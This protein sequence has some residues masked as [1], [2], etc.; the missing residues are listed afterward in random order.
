M[1]TT[2]LHLRGFVPAPPERVFDAWLDADTHSAFTGS[3]ATSE[4]GMYGRF[5]AYDG[6]IEGV[7]LELDRGHRIVQSWRTSEFLTKDPDSRLE[8]LLEPEN[9]GTQVTIIQTDVPTGLAARLEE[10][11]RDYY[12]DPLQRYFTK[13]SRP[14]KKPQSSAPTRRAPAQRRRKKA[15]VSK[16]RNV[17]KKPKKKAAKKKSATRAKVSKKKVARRAPTRKTAKKAPRKTTKKKAKSPAKK[18]IKK[19]GPRGVGNKARR[20]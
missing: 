5:S 20:R 9:G 2:T 18:T 4:P 16:N 14:R 6:Y 12:L 1:E 10:G 11:W 13:R 19:A 7:H 17:P 15:K 3:R 8:V